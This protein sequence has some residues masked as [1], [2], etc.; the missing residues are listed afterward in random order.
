MDVDK[1]LKTIESLIDVSSIQ[2]NS[3]KANFF[4]IHLMYFELS[5]FSVLI[6]KLNKQRYECETFDDKSHYLEKYKKVYLSQKRMYSKFLRNL[7]N[8]TVDITIPFD[9]RKSKKSIT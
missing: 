1:E 2:F 8:G 3:I 9:R 4:P 7:E 5:E 6:R